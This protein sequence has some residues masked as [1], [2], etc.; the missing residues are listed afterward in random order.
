MPEL[1]AARGA[2]LST[3]ATP[4]RPAVRLAAAVALTALLVD[5]ASKH[6]A[7]EKL[8]G[9]APVDVV[10]DVLQL[11]LLRNPGAAFSAGESLTP[12][13]TVVAIVAALVVAWFAA[14]VRHRG[15]AVA[16]GLLFAGVV[17]N[18]IDRMFRAPGP[19]RGHVVDFLALPN[20]P[21]FNV[22]DICI[23]VAGALFVYLLVRGVHLDGSRPP[24]VADRDQS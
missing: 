23:D 15:W 3:A 12:L 6:L 14:R 7:V 10:G 16:L 17:G 13:I 5:V 4:G 2:S 24:H 8:T 18:L 22:A 19:F 1:Q 9:R 21:V 11:Q 20:W